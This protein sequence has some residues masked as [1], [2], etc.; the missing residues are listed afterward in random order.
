[1]NE[2]RLCTYDQC[3]EFTPHS[4][5]H[6]YCDTCGCKRKAENARKRLSEDDL[7]EQPRAFKEVAIR[8]APDGYRILIINDLQRPFHD[9]KTL[10]AVENFWDEFKPNLEIYNG[11]IVDLYTISSFDTN[12][13][14]R[15]YLQDELDD[16]YGWL[17]H[18]VQKNPS[19]RRIEDDG[20]H[21]DRL[22]RLLWK[23]GHEL[24]SLRA[25]DLSELLHLND[26]GIEHLDYSSVIDFLGYRIEHGY[27]TT[28]SK[29]YPTNT[30]RWMAIATGSSG[31]CGHT[32]HFS[33]Y[34]WTDARGGHS[35]TENG[36]LCRF[37]MDY[38]PFPNW[39]QA[40]T[41]GVV[42]HN[43]VYLVPTLIYP[44]GFV[45]MGEHYKR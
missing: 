33:T 37:D 3:H 13:S 43:K 15:F 4:W 17:G 19:A 7:F 5:N 42:Y 27:K 32:H 40:F 28:Q 1:M 45:A 11:D 39:Q 31:L 20:N 16:T 22:R 36:C 44:D 24:N 38:A 18:R 8:S 30:S 26:L 25:L 14:R 6:Y 29:A 35:Y 2:T 10:T 23:H 34:S 21:E 9:Q 41:W 12:P